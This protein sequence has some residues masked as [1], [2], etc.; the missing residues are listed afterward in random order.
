MVAAFRLRTSLCF[1]A[2]ALPW[3]ALAQIAPSAFTYEVVSIKP[4]KSGSGSVRVHTS[5]DR[6]AAS[7][8]SLKSLLESAFG[9]KTDDQIA[10]VPAWANSASFDIEAKM[11]ADTAAAF[12]KLSRPEKNEASQAMMRA[13]LADRF[14]LKI[15]HTTRELPLYALVIAKGGPKLT[16]AAAGGNG[17]WINSQ[18]MK[19]TSISMEDLANNLTFQVS[20]QVVDKTGLA[21]KYDFTLHWSRDDVAADAS[22][23]AAPSIFTALQEQLGLRLDPMKGPVDTIVI[24]RLEPPSEN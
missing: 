9:L 1:I 4:D 7:N 6:Y 5:A 14:Q 23:P 20:R 16:A 19:A 15:H 8:L 18:D 17:I 21:G 10:G 24:D 2:L 22:L 12:N 11:D 3:S 13:M